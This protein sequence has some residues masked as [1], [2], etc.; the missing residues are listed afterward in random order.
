MV[1]FVSR[2]PTEITEYSEWVLIKECRLCCFLGAAEYRTQSLTEYNHPWAVE[3]QNS[4]VYL[5]RKRNTRLMEEGI[6]SCRCVT[7]ITVVD[8]ERMS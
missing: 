1:A 4:G 7:K 6:S 8:F 3:A 2:L 5:D